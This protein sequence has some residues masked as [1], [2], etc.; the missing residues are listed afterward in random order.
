MFIQFR[1]QWRSPVL[2]GKRLRHYRKA[3]RKRTIGLGGVHFFKSRSTWKT[4]VQYILNTVH[5]NSRLHLPAWYGPVI[6]IPVSTSDVSL[7]TNRSPEQKNIRLAS[8]DDVNVLHKT[9]KIYNERQSTYPPFQFSRNH[10]SCN[11]IVHTMPVSARLLSVALLAST[12]SGFGVSTPFSVVSQV[13]TW[14]DMR[15]I[16]TSASR[17]RAVLQ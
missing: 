17:R 12:V 14:H 5:T 1:I 11:S 16:S 9:C 4:T 15:E 3:R 8:D 10:T 2:G 7:P 13:M 6:C